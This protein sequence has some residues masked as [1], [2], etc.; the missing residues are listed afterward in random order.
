MVDGLALRHK[1]DDTVIQSFENT[2]TILLGCVTQV[3]G[4]CVIRRIQGQ[5]SS[6]ATRLT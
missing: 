4:R 2:A 3:C 1:R 6:G 5:P